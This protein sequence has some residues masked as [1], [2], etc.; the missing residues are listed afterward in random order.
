LDPGELWGYWR[1][2]PGDSIE[3]SWFSGFH[4]PLFRLAVRG[5]TLRGMVVHR[6][7]I[8]ARDSVTGIPSQ[9]APVPAIAW[10]VACA[11]RTGTA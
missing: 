7:D 6:T 8:L 1:P 3:V 9:P 2:L 5:D 10:R 11:R 4:G